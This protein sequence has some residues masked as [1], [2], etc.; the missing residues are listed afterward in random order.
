MRE[1]SGIEDKSD[2]ENGLSNDISSLFQRMMDFSKVQHFQN[3]EL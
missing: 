2:T 1:I 3:T